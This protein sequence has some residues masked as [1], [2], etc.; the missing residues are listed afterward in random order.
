MPLEERTPEKIRHGLLEHTVGEAHERSPFW[1]ARLEAAGGAPLEAFHN[2]PL[3]TKPEAAAAGEALY[4]DGFERNLDRVVLSSGT[5]REGR[6]VLCVRRQPCEDEAVSRYL[7]LWIDGPRDAAPQRPTGSVVELWNVAHGLPSGAASPGV[8]RVPWMPHVNFLELALSAL[9]DASREGNGRIAIL[10]GSVSALLTVAAGARHLGVEL[11]H[12]GVSA[13]ATNSYEATS[14]T[15]RLLREAFGDVAIH[16]SYSLSE[17][18]SPA[19]ECEDCGARH[20]TV[21]PILPELFELSGRGRLDGSP[22]TVGRLVLTGLAP[23]VQRTPLLRYDT[24]DLV[25]ATGFCPAEGDE[26]F[27]PLGRASDAAIVEVDGTARPVVLPSHLYELVD[28]LEGVAR[29]PHPI[30]QL[31]VLPPS[32]LGPPRAFARTTG[33]R[34]VVVQVVVV[35][36]LDAARTA[37][38]ADTLRDGLLSVNPS[39]RSFVASGGELQVQTVPSAELPDRLFKP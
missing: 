16:D 18:T 33:P 38:L 25:E 13:L 1:R 19:T 39:L 2:L 35:E 22:G 8:F 21:P 24:G 31:G 17:F 15:R 12:F 30:E 26:G 23:F 20:F 10:R 34:A 27:R 4:A 36:G 5:R 3:L 14:R 9:E 11:R 32:G 6:A 37:Q 29:A 28:G 7:E